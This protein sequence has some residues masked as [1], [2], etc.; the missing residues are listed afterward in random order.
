LE[1]IDLAGKI[2]S[3]SEVGYNVTKLLKSVNEP[4]RFVNVTKSGEKL[5]KICGD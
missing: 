5:A 3:I 2:M 1:D 4:K